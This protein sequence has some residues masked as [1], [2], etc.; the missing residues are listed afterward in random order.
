MLARLHVLRQRSVL[1]W[2]GAG[3]VPASG[4]EFDEAVEQYIDEVRAAWADATAAGPKRSPVSSGV[5]AAA[6]PDFVARL[7]EDP[8]DPPSTV[9]FVGFPGAAGDPGQRRF[10]VDAALSAFVQVPDEAVLYTQELSVS[11]AP[12]G[13]QFVWLR[14]DPEV[15]DR[16][17]R[18]LASAAE[19][20]QRVWGG[21]SDHDPWAEQ[22]FTPF[23]DVPTFLED[24]L[25]A[26]SL[27]TRSQGAN[28]DDDI[29][30][31]RGWP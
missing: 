19:L 22:A 11:Q 14:R 16:L 6:P 9:L 31:P 20:Q 24:S 15:L 17:Q 3:V 30:L 4:P 5:G 12:L 25:D 7:V 10:Y 13:G 18:A 28:D 23:P 21:P 1:G 8:A 26:S 29:P 27:P 2:T